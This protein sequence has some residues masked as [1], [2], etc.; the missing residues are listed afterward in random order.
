MSQVNTL[1][2]RMDKSFDEVKGMM[3]AFDERVRAIEKG[4][5]GCQAIVAGRLD[6]AWKKLDE[7][8]SKLAEIEKIVSDQVLVVANLITSQKQLKEIMRWV[9]GIFTMIL[10]AVLIA[11]I[12]GQAQVVFK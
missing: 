2:E 10:A 3:S 8:T 4:E 11:L 7:H 5:A 1:G 9:L 6:A 12:T